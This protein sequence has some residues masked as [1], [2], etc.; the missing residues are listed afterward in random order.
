MR[1]LS[2][3]LLVAVSILLLIALSV[4]ALILD[5][6]FRTAAEEATEERL[7]TQLILLMSSADID[8]QGQLEM[9]EV[10]PEGRFM[11]P[12]SGLFGFVSGP[13]GLYWKSL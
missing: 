11:A 13:D 10:L 12:G 7:N 9:P 4:T 8:E 2:A 3:R 6:I 5:Q 1:S